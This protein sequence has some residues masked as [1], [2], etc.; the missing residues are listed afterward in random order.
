MVI[1]SGNMDVI[2]T[3]CAG[4]IGARVCMMLLD[5][6]DRVAGMDDMNGLSYDP[7]LKEKRL[8]ELR[9][10][11]GFSFRK[12]DISDPAQTEDFFNGL[13]GSFSPSAV[14]NLAAHAGVRLSAEMPLEFYQ[15]NVLGTINLLEICRG[16]GIKK[17]VFISSS[18]VYGEGGDAPS[19]EDSPADKP[20]SPYAA[21]K[22]AGEGICHSYHKIFGTDVS[23]LRYFTV[24][25]PA[26]RPDM[27][28][29]RFVRAVA[30]G[31][32][33]VV[34]G[35]GT[36]SRDFTFL[37]DAARATVLSLKEVGFE[38]INIAGG[39]S[40]RLGDVIALIEDG[41]GKKAVIRN[42]P[43][44]PA[45]PLATRADVSKAKKILGWEPQV[46]IEEGIKSC[47]EWYVEN[48]DW[49]SRLNM[50]EV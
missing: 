45:D 33:I 8:E 21:S 2:V 34:F 48:R 43:M 10:R 40:A 35:D 3:G 27:S 1:V 30:E 16:G 12:A 18:S 50:P 38:A 49:A 7:L 31:E 47:V 25:G 26:G 9:R 17:F 15:T 20:L 11:E 13:D 24:Y 28:I 22:S 14:I 4:F 6:G 37:D 39:A 46:G 32:E 5:R 19:T 42:E 36:Q 44:H 29:F 23:A 41:L